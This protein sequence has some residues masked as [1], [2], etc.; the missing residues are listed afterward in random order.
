[1]YAYIDRT[2]N[3][4]KGACSHLCRYCFMIGMRRR[5]NQDPT[6]RLDENE[7]KANLGSGLFYFVGSSTDV[8]AADVPS[9]WIIR[10]LNH[11]NEYP[12]NTYQLQSKNPARILEF[13]SHPSFSDK[14]HVIICTTL[15]SDTD[16]PGI[17]NAPSMAERVAAMQKLS[18]LG[19]QTMMTVEP[20]IAFSSPE[21]FAD[22]I[23]SCNPM[24]VNIGVNTSRTVKLQEP[25]KDEFQALMA[26]LQSRNINVHLKK[27]I[28]RM[29]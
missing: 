16:H 3:P 27:N 15:E 26:E 1:M 12:L 18:E 28:D 20:M 29:M 17:S 13:Q 6:L 21:N 25:T 11:L 4:I 5:F 2:Y 14:N 7:L 22:L 23:A 19:F 8:F 24:Q 10:V 9:E